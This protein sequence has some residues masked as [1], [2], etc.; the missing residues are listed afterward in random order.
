MN[1]WR[2]EAAPAPIDAP[3]SVADHTG[4][5]PPK[6][7]GSILRVID[8]PPEAADSAERQRQIGADHDKRAGAHLLCAA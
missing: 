4:I 1:V 7:G 5:L 8:Y 2:T 3:D 6:N